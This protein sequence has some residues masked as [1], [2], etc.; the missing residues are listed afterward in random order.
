MLRDRRAK[1]RRGVRQ[2]RIA[3][4][5]QCLAE[6]GQDAGRVLL[7]PTPMTCQMPAW[8]A[9]NH[10]ARCRNARLARAESRFGRGLQRRADRLPV[11]HTSAPDA[12]SW[13]R[14]DKPAWR[15][16]WKSS[17]SKV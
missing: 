7:V 4:R 17:T 12:V 5:R 3:A 11:G 6:G 2:G 16:R 9:R 13:V 15:R 10:T 14:R 1:V 8:S